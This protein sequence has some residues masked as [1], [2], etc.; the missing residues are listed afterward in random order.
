V[1]PLRALAF[2]LYFYGLTTAACLLAGV[3][4]LLFARHRSLDLARAWVTAVLAGARIICG[5]RVEVTGR[6]HLPLQGPALIAC[7]HQSAV[8]T[9]LW[10]TLLDA[11]SYVM[12]RELT[13]IPVFGALLVHAGMIPVDRGAGAGALRQLLAETARMASRGRQIV[14]FPQGTRV[15]PGETVPLQPG[16]AAV[17]RQTGLPVIPVALDSG[18]LWGR[19]FLHRLPGVIHVAILPPISAATPRRAMLESIGSAWRANND[20]VPDK[21]ARRPV[22]NS[23][24]ATA[25]KLMFTGK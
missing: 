4:V 8:D 11:P 10:F 3:P 16:V 1:R 5:M 25:G 20:I 23:V 15:P 14:I 6:Q 2:Q 12:K 13:R 9:L 22:D 17:S 18:R 21:R 7:Q 19:G 24:D